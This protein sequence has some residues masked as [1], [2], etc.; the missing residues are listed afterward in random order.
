MCFH[1]IRLQAHEMANLL[2]P[3]S[4]AIPRNVAPF[5]QRRLI[6]T[7]ST[8]VKTEFG[9][10]S[11]TSIKPFATAWSLF[12]WYVV[13]SRFSALLSYLIEFLW[14]RAISAR[15]YFPGGGGRKANATRVWT[16]LWYFLPSNRIKTSKY[17]TESMVGFLTDRG[18]Y[19]PVLSLPD[20]RYTMP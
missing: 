18:Q 6:S 16:R 1:V 20:I 3:K 9:C 12:C 17:P 8:D 15:P 4:L 14:F 2:H 11:P 10:S 7:T 19:L 13:H 5:A